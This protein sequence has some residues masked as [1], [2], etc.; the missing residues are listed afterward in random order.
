MHPTISRS[1]A[2]ITLLLAPVLASG[3]SPPPKPAGP[4]D[5]VPREL[6]LALLNLGPGM[7]GGANLRVGKVPDDVPP[8]LIPP[9]LQ[10]LGSTTQF[11]SSVI[12]LTAPQPPDSALSLYEAHLLSAGWS[13]P[14]VPQVRPMRGFVPADATAGGFE[15]LNVVCRGDSFATFSGAYRRSGGSVLKVTYNRG[16]RYSMCKVRQDVNTYRSPY[17]DA[18]VP[19]LR[20]PLGA[21]QSGGS[22]MTASD[23]SFSLSTRLSTRLKPGEVVAHYDKQM[24]D[25]GWTSLADGVLEFLAA[26]TYRKSDDQGRTWT[27]MLFSM[28][29]PDSLQQDVTLRIAKSQQAVAK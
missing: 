22:G 7:A 8:E 28:S 26:H 13:K 15:Q 23:N 3:Q 17:D 11:E 19:L 29:F 4:E 24:R 14:P 10:V 6:V 1:L 2:A 21:I 16:S 25:Q 12:V 18:P 5:P 9:G 20:A 27:G